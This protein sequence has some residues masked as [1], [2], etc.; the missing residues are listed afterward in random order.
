MI[1]VS[2]ALYQALEKFY[3]DIGT[4]NGEHKMNKQEFC[5]RSKYQKELQLFL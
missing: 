1:F 3:K 5:H 4:K 2:E